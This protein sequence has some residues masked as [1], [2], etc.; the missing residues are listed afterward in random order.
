MI[1]EYIMITK[2]S[3][4]LSGEEYLFIGHSTNGMNK[5]KLDAST[6]NYMIKKSMQKCRN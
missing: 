4:L 1:N 3:K 5:E 6:L 2:R